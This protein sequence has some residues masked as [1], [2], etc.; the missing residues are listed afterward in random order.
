MQHSLALRRSWRMSSR[1]TTTRRGAHNPL[2]WTGTVLIFARLLSVCCRA[3]WQ[4]HAHE[5]QASPFTAAPPVRL[6]VRC[7]LAHN[8]PGQLPQPAGTV[9]EQP[10][11]RRPSACIWRRRR[12]RSVRSVCLRV[13]LPS[14]AVRGPRRRPRR[15]SLPCLRPGD[16]E[17][18]EAAIRS[19]RR[20]LGTREHADVLEGLSAAAAVHEAVGQWEA[21]ERRRGAGGGWEAS[22]AAEP[23]GS[24]VWW[25]QQ[26]PAGA[27]HATNPLTRC[28]LCLEV[29]EALLG[30]DT[31][32]TA[33]LWMRLGGAR[34]TLRLWRG[35]TQAYESAS[36]ALEVAVGEQDPLTQEA[37]AA[38]SAAEAR[39]ARTG[40]GNGG[41]LLTAAA[42]ARARGGAREDLFRM[43]NEPPRGAVGGGCGCFGRRPHSASPPPPPHQ[44]PRLLLSGS[45]GPPPAAEQPLSTSGIPGITASRAHDLPKKPAEPDGFARVLGRAPSGLREL[46]GRPSGGARSLQGGG[47]SRSSAAGSASGWST[48][49]GATPRAGGGSGPRL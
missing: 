12:R 28:V 23:P 26:K 38:R 35:A 45:S 3:V 9:P 47:G 41:G 22:F 36:K 1:R 30:G 44:P 19:L 25:M 27:T 5:S 10:V 33:A 37:E 43:D 48:G 16:A 7:Q 14:R 4:C 24:G 42:F 20:A 49:G 13:R 6:S 18:H 40:G 11:D 17:A 15:D 2:H 39:C 46:G 29:A 34:A 8:G 32:E 31:W 21:A